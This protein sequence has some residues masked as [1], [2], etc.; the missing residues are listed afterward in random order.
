MKTHRIEEM[1]GGWF[2]GDF[3]PSVIKTTDFEVG[4]KHF[5]KGETFPAHFHK[6]SDEVTVIVKGKVKINGIVFD[7]GDI[8]LQEKGEAGDFTV[9]EDTIVIA[10]K[11]PS[12]KNDKY[13][14]EEN[15]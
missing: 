2:I 7:M 13:F 1:V 6:K 14:V 10:I 11:V 8:I 4:V 9:L 3:E 15:V 5:L 12:V